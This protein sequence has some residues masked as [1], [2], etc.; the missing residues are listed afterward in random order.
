MASTMRTIDG[1]DKAKRAL[2][3]LILM[4]GKDLERAVHISEL[5]LVGRDW[6]EIMLGH[7][8]DKR[9]EE[10]LGGT[11]E[12][13]PQWRALM[14]RTEVREAAKRE[15]HATVAATNLSPAELRTL[16]KVVARDPTMMIAQVITDVLREKVDEGFGE[17]ARRLG[18][19][20]Q[21][22]ERPEIVETAKRLVRKNGH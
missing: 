4:N 8:I 16:L 22:F 20:A 15:Y 10:L 6:Q 12:S 5:S 18:I 9:Y 7:A 13:D 1:R 11:A 19:R 14:D 21:L 17:P 3:R 2:H